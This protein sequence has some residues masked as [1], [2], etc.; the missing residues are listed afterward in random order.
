M[1]ADGAFRHR[2]RR[3]WLSVAPP[4]IVFAIVIG[5]WELVSQ[6]V[7][8]PDR[9]RVL[10]PP[11]ES[12]VQ[13]GF[14]EWD[15]L[16]QI[17]SGLWL[18]GQVTMLGLAISVVIG[19]TVAVMMSQARW[20]ERIIH[21]Y[22]VVLQTIPII[23]IVPIVG[24]WFSFAFRSRVLVAVIISLFPIITNTLF[25]LKSVDRGL[26]DLFTLHGS[27]WRTR[28]WK[29]RARAAQPAFFTGLRIAAGMA[30]IGS[31]VGDFFF[32]RGDQM[33]LGRLLAIYHSRV[34][35]T[36]LFTAIFFSSML[37]LTLFVA[38]GLL[39][40]FATRAWYVPARRTRHR[41]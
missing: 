10:L 39:G 33:G 17:L 14:L 6:V 22:A 11:P 34:Q 29:L 23:A 40:R 9:Q 5:A 38:F 13:D 16:S 7:M 12:T 21:P 26:E 18:T 1:S 20:V 8:T 41:P 32:R 4:L 3:W 31:I 15:H 36:L 2:G 37:G 28:L 27:N 24:L 19:V 30:V 35:P 25:G